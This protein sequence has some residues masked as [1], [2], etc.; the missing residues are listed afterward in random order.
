M[1]AEAKTIRLFHLEEVVQ[2]TFFDSFA[3]DFEYIIRITRGAMLPF[4]ANEYLGF[5]L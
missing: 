5:W 3:Q 2:L 4:G 1:L